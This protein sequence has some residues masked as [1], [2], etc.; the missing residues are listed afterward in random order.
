M[1]Y[2]ISVIDT[3][4]RSPHTPEE[5][6]AINAI[7]DEMVNLGYRVFERGSSLKFCL[8][9]QGD[10]DLYVRLGPTS[11]WD[12][13]AGHAILNAAGGKVVDLESLIEMR[14]ESPRCSKP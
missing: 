3:Q 8:I 7:N 2:I 11:I 4:T 12:I 9:A 5:I 14:Y 10:A 1:K 13:A 6:S